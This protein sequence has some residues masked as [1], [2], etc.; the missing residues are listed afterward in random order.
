MS[1]THYSP[2]VRPR[3]ALLVS[4]LVD[5]MR[6]SVGFAA[7]KLLERAGCEVHVPAQTCCG[8]P[9]YNNGDLK[10]TEALAKQLI[11]DFETFDYVV[12][13]S[14]SCAGMLIEHFPRLFATHAGWA[15]RAATLAARS[16]ELLEFLVSVRGFD[17]IDASYAGSVTYHDSCSSSREL[18]VRAQPRR[19][20]AQVR[21]LELVEIAQ[22]RVCCGF[23]GTFSL[24]YGDISARIV[25]E[26]VA[27]LAATGAHTL[28]GG[29]LGCLMNIAG[30]FSR[31]GRDMKVYHV[32]EVLA[33]DAADL[34]PICAPET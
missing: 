14:G 24:K 6:P 31:E 4:C 23:G 13:P 20:L 26:K 32:A 22:W 27:N 12:A 1:E 9:A 34:A 19:L 16:H 5:L 33:G 21:G 29:D 8:Q 30:R 15:A 7:A 25:T 2:P 28:L 18:G 11:V 10:N 3:V 17:A